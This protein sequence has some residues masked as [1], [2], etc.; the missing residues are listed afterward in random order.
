MCE[1][2]SPSDG[3]ESYPPKCERWRVRTGS[4]RIA[5]NIR[6]FPAWSTPVMKLIL[7]DTGKTSLATLRLGFEAG[8]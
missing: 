5:T 6:S 7:F 2:L 3:R 1:G 8:Q 4:T